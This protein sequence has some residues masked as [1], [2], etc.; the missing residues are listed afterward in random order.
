MGNEKLRLPGLPERTNGSNGRIEITK[1][2][3]SRSDPLLSA[4]PGFEHPF[5]GHDRAVS[6]ADNVAIYNMRMELD[7]RYPGPM[8]QLGRGMD[9]TFYEVPACLRAENGTNG[10]NRDEVVDSRRKRALVAAIGG[11]D[12]T[13]YDQVNKAFGKEKMSKAERESLMQTTGLMGFP[14]LVVHYGEYSGR[15]ILE[16]S[17]RERREH[18]AGLTRGFFDALRDAEG[19]GRD[20][21][22]SEPTIPNNQLHSMG[23][24]ANAYIAAREHAV[25]VLGTSQVQGVPNTEQTFLDTFHTLAGPDFDPQEAH[26][27]DIGIQSHFRHARKYGEFFDEMGDALYDPD[28]PAHDEI[29]DIFSSNL[30]LVRT[31]SVIGLASGCYAPA[32]TLTMQ[33]RYRETFRLGQRSEEH[34]EFFEEVRDSIRDFQE[35]FYPRLDITPVSAAILYNH[36]AFS[37]PRRTVIDPDLAPQI[38]KTVVPLLDKSEGVDALLFPLMDEVGSF[39]LLHPGK[40]EKTKIIVS[41]GG[42]TEDA[43]R[44]QGEVYID[45]QTHEIDWPYLEDP[46]APESA[47]VV[48]K[49]LELTLRKMNEADDIMMPKDTPEPASQPNGSRSGPKVKDHPVSDVGNERRLARL[50]RGIEE[51]QAQRDALAARGHHIYDMVDLEPT[52]KIGLG[53]R[54]A[55]IDSVIAEVSNTVRKEDLPAILRVLKLCN[56]QGAQKAGMQ[57]MKADNTLFRLKAGRYRLMFEL[58][59][60]GM[61]FLNI[62]RR[63]DTY[64][65]VIERNE[66]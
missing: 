65:R 52:E 10:S 1:I 18:I 66:R 7:A 4:D 20:K 56:E 45:P 33:H 37:S 27:V 11:L 3:D 30:D 61:H 62:G 42:E 40:K 57:K 2:D 32:K 63:E 26:K 9:R 44:L 53:P 38:I 48:N 49:I 58:G 5:A 16:M 23:L 14:S 31:D 25:G 34:A 22:A 21:M 13:A 19:V 41:I 28:H 39:I 50:E 6:T 12:V 46:H 15:A 36:D 60:N 59:E 54:I 8:R 64:K 43:G 47:V 17:P 24:N 51:L 35:E 55:D 29:I